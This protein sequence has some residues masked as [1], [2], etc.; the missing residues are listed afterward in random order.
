MAKLLLGGSAAQSSKRANQILNGDDDTV[1]TAL[2]YGE[3]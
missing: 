3:W 2:I 1:S